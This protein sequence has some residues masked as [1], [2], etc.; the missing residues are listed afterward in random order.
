MT[1]DV[2]PSTP[3][4]RSSAD[5]RALVVVNSPSSGPRRLGTWLARYGVAVVEAG[6]WAGL[7]ASLSGFDAL[8]MLG[9]GMLPHEDERAAWLPRERALTAEALE[10]GVPT[11][12]VCFGA[13]LIAHVAG[14]RVEANWGP[15]EHG[16]VELRATVGARE[17]PVFSALPVAYPVIE[18]HRDQITALPP[19][20]VRLASSTGCA[21]QAFRLGPAAWGVQFHPEVPVDALDAWDPAELRGDGYELGAVRAEALRRRPALDGAAETLVRTFAATVGAGPE[22]AEG[23]QACGSLPRPS[24]SGI[25]ANNRWV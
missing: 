9:A 12:G 8:V 4:P 10:R 7:P 20:A 17:D 1:I 6:G 25:A 24:A 3:R 14:G 2:T 19:G 23:D 5:L 18:N 22:R 11:L 16:A 15:P 13:Q 21:N